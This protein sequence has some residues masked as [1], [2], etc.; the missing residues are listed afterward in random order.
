MSS[1]FFCGQASIVWWNW[2]DLIIVISGVADQ[3]IVPVYDI[4]EGRAQGER[5]NA[6][7]LRVLRLLRLVRVVRVFKIVRIFMES[8]MHWTESPFISVLYHW[9]DWFECD[10]DGS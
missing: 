8:D 10:C 1:I 4:I 3:W 2:L 5:F 9:C 7:G 6:G